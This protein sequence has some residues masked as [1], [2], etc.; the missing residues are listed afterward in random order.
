MM[1]ALDIDFKTPL[2]A[3]GF[4]GDL[5]VPSDPDYPASLRRFAKNT[6]RNAAL[7][8]FVRSSQDVSHVINFA[9]ANSIPLVVRG[10][11]HSTSGASSIENGIVVDLSRYLNTVRVDEENKLG[12]VGGGASWKDVDE[13]AIKYG[14]ASVGGTVNHTGVGGLTLGGGYGW[15][16]GEHGMVID[17]LVQATLVT[18]DGAIRTV[19]EELEPD[20]FWAIRGG[21]TNFGCVTEFVYRLHPQRATVYAG[22]LV[23]PPSMIEPVTATLD[24]WYSEASKKE[25]VLLVT[26]SKGPTGDPAIVVCVL[27][28]GDEE[29]GKEKFKKILDL[30]PVVNLAGMLPYEKLNAMQ[31]EAIPY[32]IYCHLTGITRGSLPPSAASAIFEILLTIAN[33]PSPFKATN[34]TTNAE[35]P[36]T[37]GM[38]ILWE[39][40]NLKKQSTPAP[41]ATAFRM[42]VPY[43]MAPL[44]IFWSAEGMEASQEAK[45]RLKEMK[46]FCDAQLWPT[47]GPDGPNVNGT[48][49][50]NSESYSPATTDSA[51]LLF[52][53]NYSR[54]QEIKAKYDPYMMFKSW[55]PIQPAGNA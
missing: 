19:N 24:E 11:G 28:N 4:T 31:N 26:T 48:G 40:W 3:A 25:A 34:P 14:L 46:A 27:F 42:R 22:P 53:D 43:P 39:Y 16:T 52:G 29:E 45:G 54:L 35:E 49:Y 1:S 47:F 17:N 15:L 10:G 55:F 50:R 13:E 9:A 37:I 32:N 20:L 44:G 51:M 38:S 7:V 6:Q 36:N 18:A 21:G 33:A 5:V 41:D 23:F 30:G 8:A 12:Y 2:L